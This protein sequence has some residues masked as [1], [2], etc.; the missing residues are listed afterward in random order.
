MKEHE[1]QLAKFWESQVPEKYKHFSG[2]EFDSKMQNYYQQVKENIFKYLPMHSF[3]SN[4]IIVDWGVGGG[5]FSSF[6]ANY[7][8][9]IG[10]DIAQS[11]LDKASQYLFS[12]KQAF[13]SSVLVDKLENAE[14]LQKYPIKLLFSVSVIQHFISVDYWRKVAE[15]WKKLQP[16]YLAVQT[17]HGDKN[18]DHPDQYYISEK[19]YILGLRLTTKEVKSCVADKYKLLYNNL[20]NDNHSMYEYFVFSRKN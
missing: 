8:R 3:L 13:H 9:I 5:L 6:L 19:N 17:R 20:I 2:T 14:K 4:D 1:E 18:E 11:S 16:E 10:V 7:G 15:L 12:Q